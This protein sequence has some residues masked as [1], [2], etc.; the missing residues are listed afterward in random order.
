MSITTDIG[1]IELLAAKTGSESYSYDK[2]VTVGLGDLLASDP[3]KIIQNKDG[4]LTMT[5]ADA[6]YDEVDS[7][8][9]ITEMRGS[10]ITTGEGDIRLDSA[11]N[12]LIE[13]SH[14]A[15]GLNN[16]EAPAGD[17]ILLAV[18]DVTIKEATNTYDEETKE[19]HGS[20][21]M[22][23]VVQHQAVEVAKAAIAVDDAKKQLEQAKKDYKQYERDVDNLSTT[24]AALETDYQNKVP[25]VNYE[26]I[27]E[28][29]DIL[30]DVKGDK[31]WYVAGVALAAANV[32]A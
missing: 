5:F 9:R 11:N 15:A 16:E 29:R 3:T 30:N 6:T 17:V 25:G 19:V 4:R 31:E 32:T 20:A 14:L 24:L 28:L 27:L 12:I 21:E 23:M 1:D 18:N 13:G 26:D 10:Q 8:T 2:S 22:S 7:K